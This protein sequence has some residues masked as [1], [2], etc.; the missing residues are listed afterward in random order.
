MG[1]LI[2]IVCCGGFAAIFGIGD[3]SFHKKRQETQIEIPA[4]QDRHR[5]PRHQTRPDRGG[6]GHPDGRA[7]GQDPDHDPVQ[8]ACAS[9]RQPSPAATRWRSRSRISCPKICAIMKQHS[10]MA[11]KGDKT[12]RRKFLQDMM[13]DLVKSVGEKMKGFSRKE[14]VDY[15]KVDHGK[16]LAGGRIRRNTRS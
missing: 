8:R 4:A 3:L 6:S 10:C 7:H 11:F 12:K 1:T 2:P 16:S 13:V 9:R 5:R 15:Y 14:T